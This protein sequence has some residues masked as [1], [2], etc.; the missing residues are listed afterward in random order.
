MGK[1]T[2]MS[3]GQALAFGGRLTQLLPELG[4]D[5]A[6]RW[7]RAPDEAVRRFLEGLQEGPFMVMVVKEGEDLQLPNWVERVEKD[8]KEPT[9]TLELEVVEFSNAD[10]ARTSNLELRIQAKGEQGDLGL[11]H[12]QNL[13]SKYRPES[14]GLRQRP[15]PGRCRPQTPCSRR[16]TSGPR[17]RSPG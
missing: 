5:L 8:A 16:G 12:A 6:Q 1:T 11:R 4:H 7:M 13:L 17:L 10:E 2:R 15:G 3:T 14:F 9:G